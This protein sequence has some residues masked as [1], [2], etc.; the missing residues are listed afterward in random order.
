MASISFG[1]LGYRRTRMADVARDAGLSAGA[2]YTYV[3]S[4]EALFHLVVAE[5]FD[6]SGQSSDLPLSAPPFDETL[7]LIGNGLKEKGATPLLR[8]AVKIAS[9]DDVQSE[10][11]AI[12][13]EHYDMVATL[14][15]VLPVIERCASDLP[16]LDAM[17]FGR[18]RRR[19]LNL[20]AE[21]IDLRTKSGHFFDFSDAS[22]TA[23][24]IAEG[25]A[26][27]AWKRHEGHDATRFDDAV[28]RATIAQFVCRALIGPTS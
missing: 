27:S 21:Y 24:I 20:L 19:Q 28:C 5:G 14:S 8:S 10:L 1:R 17:Y 6:S 12:V 23:Q 18:G 7:R 13:L 4:K 26:W 2:I 9:P 22:T 3:E 15:R 25:V 11:V 16:E